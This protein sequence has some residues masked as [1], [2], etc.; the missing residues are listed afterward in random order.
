MKKLGK[1]L[2]WILFL[3]T[4]VTTIVLWQERLELKS[5]I[6][7]LSTSTDSTGTGQITLDD[8]GD[9]QKYK[10]YMPFS[11]ENQVKLKVS[12]VGCAC[13][14]EYPQ[15]QVDS[16]LSADDNASF[17]VNKLFTIKF[18]NEL[19]ESELSDIKC[20]TQCYY[21]ILTGNWMSNGFGM[22]RLV[23]ETGEII[24]DEACCGGG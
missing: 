17:L 8:Q 3:A 18:A 12:Y 16:V 9:C 14:P 13:G 22:N 2:P 19:Q 21:Y 11:G 1:Y 15:Y 23:L 6:E 20:D 4:S 10:K 7:K 5:E 24:M